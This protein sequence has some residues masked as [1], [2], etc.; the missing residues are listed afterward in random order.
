MTDD[1]T[2][3]DVVADCWR[4]LGLG[5]AD[6]A[7]PFRFPVLATHGLT[8]AGAPIPAARTVVLRAADPV[9]RELVFH[10]DR[11]AMKAAEI[12]V[13]PR[14]TLVFHDPVDQV[15]LRVVAN[16]SLHSGDARAESA[17]AAC[18]P[19]SRR[20]YRAR[21][22]PGATIDGPFD[23]DEGAASDGDGPENEGQENFAAIL[24]EPLSLD[25]LELCDPTHRRAVFQWA[26]DRFMGRWV[27]P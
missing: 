9:R 19:S 6:A 17:W 7:S 20:L 27:V 11:R 4:R 16:A 15:Q 8:Q 10:T 23:W 2:L 14:V 21:R 12:A 13:A 26:G 3:P 25:W 5:A 1:M 18:S 22:G 24:C